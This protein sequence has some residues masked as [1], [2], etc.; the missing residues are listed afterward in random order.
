ME[1]IKHVLVQ[2]VSFTAR[3]AEHETYFWEIAIPMDAVFITG[4]K[5]IRL[6]VGLLKKTDQT[7]YREMIANSDEDASYTWCLL[8]L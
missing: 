5:Q 2:K 7:A 8:N 6:N 3:K 4:K 1:R